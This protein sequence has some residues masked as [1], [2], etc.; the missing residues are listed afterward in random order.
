MLVQLATQSLLFRTIRNK[1]Q[2]Q[3]YPSVAKLSEV[4]SRTV[5]DV[6][7]RRPLN[8]TKEFYSVH[9]R[10]PTLLSLNILFDPYT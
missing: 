7:E 8:G 6:E 5:F 1:R 3:L 2:N 4:V 9:A 10:A